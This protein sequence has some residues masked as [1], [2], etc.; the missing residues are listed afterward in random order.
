MSLRQYFIYMKI[1]ATLLLAANRLN[2][3]LEHTYYAALFDGVLVY[4]IWRC[5]LK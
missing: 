1:A 2:T 3:G 4:T 5:N